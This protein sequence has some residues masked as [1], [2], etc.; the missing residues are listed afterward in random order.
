M[1]W[2]LSMAGTVAIIGVGA[3]IYGET[4][5]GAFFLTGTALMLI[6]IYRELRQLKNLEEQRKTLSE[7]S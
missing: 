2:W 6:G 3:L 1:S 5:W 7:S 4:R